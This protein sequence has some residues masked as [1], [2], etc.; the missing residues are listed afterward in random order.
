MKLSEF[1]KMYLELY[2]VGKKQSIRFD[3]KYLKIELSLEDDMIV[4]EK[5]NNHSY[6][7]YDHDIDRYIK[8]KELQ[9]KFISSESSL[10]LR[11][12]DVLRYVDFLKEYQVKM[13]ADKL[14]RDLQVKE[15]IIKKVKI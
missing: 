4:I 12:K 2:K 14:A 7:L 6:R 5:L 9:V 13:L 15:E 1:V 11:I 3:G 10:D 8:I